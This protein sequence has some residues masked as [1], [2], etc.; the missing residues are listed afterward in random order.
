MY[1]FASFKYDIVFETYIRTAKNKVLIS[2][3]A[4]LFQPHSLYVNSH[5]L[6]DENAQS[7]VGISSRKEQI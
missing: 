1:D 6:H 4:Q 7:P 3:H 2:R 5:A